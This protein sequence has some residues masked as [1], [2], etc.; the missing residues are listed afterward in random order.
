MTNMS[1]GV[2]TKIFEVRR[3]VGSNSTKK[4]SLSILGT[5][6][7]PARH[8]GFETFAENLSIYLA[9]R[10]WEVTVY[11]QIEHPEIRQEIKWKGVTLR[12]VESSIPGAVG[13]IVYDC[14]CVLDAMRSDAIALTLGYN[15]A[16][17]DIL[18][19]LRGIPN[20]FNMDGIEWRRE[21]WGF[22]ERAW[23]YLN[24]RIGCHVGNHLIADH[25]EIKKHLSTRVDPKKITMIPY[26]SH[27]I[28]RGD[29]KVLETMELEPSGYALVVARPEPENSILEIIRSF[30]SKNRECKLLV[31]G[32]YRPEVNEYHRAVKESANKDVLFAGAIYDSNV[33]SSLRYYARLYIHGHTVGGTNPSLVE[34]MGAGNPILAHDN[35]F[36]RWVAGS[37]NHYFGDEN[38]LNMELDNLLANKE[39]LARMS[40][41]SSARHQKYFTWEIILKQYEELLMQ[42]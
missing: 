19:R 25:P 12:N 29:L 26:G 27:K 1:N 14:K 24:E 39:E 22:M 34:A 2:S 33:V 5:R 41:S 10:G 9:D 4:L 8:G 36:N 21:K 7:I 3:T 30:S 28:S 15:T 13:T 42:L 16:I 18:F 37:H 11:C 31:L 40:S 38:K 17:F 32:D 20:V 6:G 23:L 35:V